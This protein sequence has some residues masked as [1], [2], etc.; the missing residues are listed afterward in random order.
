MAKFNP[1]KAYSEV[2]ALAKSRLGPEDAHELLDEV[3]RATDLA[4]QHGVAA[5]GIVVLDV[6][7]KSGPTGLAAVKNYIQAAYPVPK[8]GAPAI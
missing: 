7:A 8:G 2:F 5:N 6:L 4:E 3:H 1:G